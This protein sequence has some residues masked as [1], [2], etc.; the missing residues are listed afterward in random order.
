MAHPGRPQVPELDEDVPTTPKTSL[1]QNNIDQALRD[2]QRRRKERTMWQMEAERD[3]A[4]A[5]DMHLATKLKRGST[6]ASLTYPTEAA[7]T[8]G[9]MQHAG[10][11]SMNLVVD[12]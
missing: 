5:R 9:Q 3:K 11:Q 1:T 7:A 8:H 6:V 2:Q 4:A 12:L 10:S